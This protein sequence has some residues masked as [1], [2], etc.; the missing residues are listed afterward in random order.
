[1]AARARAI[2]REDGSRLAL[3]RWRAIAQYRLAGLNETEMPRALAYT[4]EFQGAA[5]GE[6]PDAAL[7]L[8][9][10]PPSSVEQPVVASWCGSRATTAGLWQRAHAPSIPL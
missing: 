7:R 4:I 1:V 2:P 10:W 3:S 9:P 5:P 6:Y 8:K